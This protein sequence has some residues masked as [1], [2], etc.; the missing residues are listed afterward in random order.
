MKRYTLSLSMI[1]GLLI[2]LSGFKGYEGYEVGDVTRDFKLKNVDGRFVSLADYPQ[3]KGFIVVFT[4]NTCPYAKLYEDR[5]IK[6][7][8][9]FAPQGY[10]VVAINANDPESQP[11]DSYENMVKRARE[12]QYPFPYLVDQTQEI[13][14][15]FGAKK[16]PEIYLLKKVGGKNK[17]VYTGAI[18]NNHN[19]ASQADKKYVEEA[20]NSL[21]SG[22]P[23]TTKMSKAIGCSIKFKS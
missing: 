21:L 13:A 11:M 22:K 4:C 17:L 5:I 16:T 18:D 12:K 23:I 15:S 7:H 14:R 19:D 9:R 6:L 2:V 20:I 1:I 10:P 3:A 8:Q